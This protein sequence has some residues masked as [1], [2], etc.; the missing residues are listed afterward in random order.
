MP[1]VRYDLAVASWRTSEVVTITSRAGHAI[2]HF[3]LAFVRR[4][5]DN[6]WSYV[7]SVMEDLTTRESALPWVIKDQEDVLVIPNDAPWQG[8]FVYEPNGTYR[9]LAATLTH[10]HNG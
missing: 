3:P 9:T 10:G 7:L 5:G 2:A 1:T 6:T 4:G 8:T